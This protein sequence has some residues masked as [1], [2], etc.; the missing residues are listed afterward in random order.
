M[1]ISNKDSIARLAS[2]VYDNGRR[3][4]PKNGCDCV[5]CFG[6]CLVDKDESVRRSFVQGPRDSV[7]DGQALDFE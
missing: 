3:G 2:S 4:M 7:V 1:A 6:Y 5:Q